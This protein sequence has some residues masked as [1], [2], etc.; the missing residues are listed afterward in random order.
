MA[1][2]AEESLEAK[3]GYTPR[4]GSGALLGTSAK[5]GPEHGGR[6]MAIGAE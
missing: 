2:D 1:A 3:H 5:K 6:I 4:S